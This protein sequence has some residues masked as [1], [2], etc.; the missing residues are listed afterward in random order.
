METVLISKRAGIPTQDTALPLVC[1]LPPP[2]NLSPLFSTLPWFPVVCQAASKVLLL[3]LKA[4][5]CQVLNYSFG[6]HSHT[7][8]TCTPLS[9]CVHHASWKGLSHPHA[10]TCLLSSSCKACPVIKILPMSL[11]QG[12]P[13]NPLSETRRL[14][15]HPVV[16]HTQVSTLLS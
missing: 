7:P 8:Q 6:L 13:C 15:L 14:P 9:N 3:T 1:W 5:D 2:G 11:F 4:F 16:S 10:N 12:V